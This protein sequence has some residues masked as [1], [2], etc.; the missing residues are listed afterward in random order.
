MDVT[1]DNEPRCPQ[2]DGEIFISEIYREWANG[3]LGP[4]RV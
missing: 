4:I 2:C 1:L 3:Q